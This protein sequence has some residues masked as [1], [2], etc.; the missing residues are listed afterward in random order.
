MFLAEVT[1]HYN[2]AGGK[3]LGSNGI[4]M[5][6]I[7]KQLEQ[8]IVEHKV[9]KKGNKIPEQ[10]DTT[11]QV[12]LGKYYKLHQQKAHYKINTE[13]G[14]QCGNMRTESIEAKTEIFSF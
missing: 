10:L 9:D 12:A 5:Q 4:P 3:Q 1:Y 14:E 8:Q 6:H 13:G 7:H 11:P 2:D